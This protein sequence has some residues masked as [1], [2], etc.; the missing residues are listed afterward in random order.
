ME[1]EIT[2][3]KTNPF[4]KRTEVHFVIKHDN[5]G[6]PNQAIIRNELAE[7]LNVKKDTIII[8]TIHSSYG[9]QHTKGYAK[10]YS[11]RKEAESIER[12]HILIRNKISEG[13]PKKKEEVEPEKPVDSEETSKEETSDE[14]ETKA[15]PEDDAVEKKQVES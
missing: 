15:A 3:K 9:L 1:I 10:V 6:T 4:F 2:D 11:S 7:S 13:K 12:E 8:D 5:Q 14:T